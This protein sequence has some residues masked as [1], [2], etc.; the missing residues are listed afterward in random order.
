MCQLTELRGSISTTRRSSRRASSTRPRVAAS[1]P[2]FEE[3]TRLRAPEQAPAAARP[4]RRPSPSRSRVLITPIGRERRR[5]YHRGRAPGPP[6][7]AP[8]GIPRPAEEAGTRLT[9]S[10]SGKSRPCRGIV[11]IDLQCLLEISRR[12]LEIFLRAILEVAPLKDGVVGLDV[13][14]RTAGAALVGPN[15]VTCNAAATAFAMSSCTAKMSV[16][17]RS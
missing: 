4:L 6:P 14:L 5:G 7:P 16:S 15:N 12:L 11:R 13:L 3:P 8:G 17:S 9:V 1:G 10:H 2:G